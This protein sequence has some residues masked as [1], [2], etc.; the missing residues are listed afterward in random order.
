M[1]PIQ[2]EGNLNLNKL[3]VGNKAFNLNLLHRIGV[4]VPKTV[5]LPN[6]LDTS[7]SLLAV[8]LE[9]LELDLEHNN[10]AVR[11]SSNLEDGENESMAGA[12]HSEL[13][14]YDLSSLADAVQRVRASGEDMHVILQPLVAAE[15]SG[16]AFGC[17]PISFSKNAVT[18]SWTGGL[19]DKLVS[20][21][22]S[23]YYVQ[24]DWEGRINDGEWGC[25]IGVLRELIYILR[26]VQNSFN[27]PVDIEWVYDGT[28]VIIVQARPVV[29]P[30]SNMLHLGSEIDFRSLPPAVRDHSK[31]RLRQ[32][33]FENSLLMAPVTIYIDAAETL[34]SSLLEKQKD[35]ECGRS[36]VLLH[37]RKVDKKVIRK[38]CGVGDVVHAKDVPIA[39]RRYSI[40][41]YPDNEDSTKALLS[42]LETG[43]NESWLSV[44]ASFDIWDAVATGIIKEVADGYIVDI[45]R[46]HFVPK[47]IVP[48]STVTTDL[49]G[50][51]IHSEWREQNVAY[52]FHDG[53]VLKEE[54]CSD[55]C[56]LTPDEVREI[57]QGLQKGFEAF[58]GAA[59][60]F[61]LLGGKKKIPYLIDLAETDSKTNE[62][63][64]QSVSSGVISSGIAN[65]RVVH[66][67][68]N[69]ESALH[70]HLADEH[71]DRRRLSG[72]ESYIIF[73]DHPSVDFIPFLEQSST[74]AVVVRTGAMLAHFCVVAREKGIPVIVLDDA[75]TFLS[76]EDGAEVSVDAQDDDL[77]KSN[78]VSRC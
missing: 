39:C 15:V 5:V 76:F 2:I 4:R 46:G 41:Y 27:Y 70:S 33:A 55:Q 52:H 28:S 1:R 9:M 24:C 20:G 23:G 73:A 17:D 74:K 29:M 68:I 56:R 67:R 35:I 32:A 71:E 49:N 18:I 72:T 75:A 10:L 45:A 54:P 43:K 64:F 50:N 21:L 19:A 47:G 57:I 25:G 16:V 38:F 62:L 8:A 11:S 3:S 77:D 14:Q 40:R 36:V 48:T 6:G 51:I 69:E 7:S 22:E 13:G 31:I 65:G 12:F 66:I 61:G 34:D 53:H 37:P 58:P 26:D 42:V 78:R 30:K 60:E 44:A 59:L 63:S